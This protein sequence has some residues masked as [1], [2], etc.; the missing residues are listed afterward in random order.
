MVCSTV[1]WALSSCDVFNDKKQS[2]DIKDKATTVEGI[3]QEIKDKIAAQDTLMSALVLKV[4]TLAQALTQAQKENVELQAQVTK[5]ESPKSTWGYMTLAVLAIAIIALILSLLKKGISK[6]EV[7]KIFSQNLDKSQRMAELKIA[8]SQLKSELNNR[9]LLS[10]E[11]D[12]RLQ[13]VESTLSSMLNE[14]HNMPLPTVTNSQDKSRQSKESE[15]LKIGYAN[16]NSGR[17]FTKILNSA[18]EGCVFSIKFKSAIK[19]EFNIISLEKIK[20]RNMW[21]EIVEYT[22][23]IEDATSFKVE[24]YGI[25]EKYDDVTWQV[26]KNLKIKLLK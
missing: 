21:Q 25:C 1:I 16:I 19:G 18:Q 8:V 9:I 4:D 14:V 5:L 26:T 17:I 23:S 3:S 24:E 22:G 10:K 20:S 12:V 2:Q 15:Y 6:E 13:T 11:L 7:D